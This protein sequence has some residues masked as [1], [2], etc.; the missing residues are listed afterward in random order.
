M[1]DI[2][3]A[4]YDDIQ[5]YEFLCR[6]YNE[7]IRYS[8]NQFGIRSPDCYGLHAT[9]LEKRRIEDYKKTK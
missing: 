5:E 9:E 3:S 2:L 1:S 4:I 7:E 8:E 6:K